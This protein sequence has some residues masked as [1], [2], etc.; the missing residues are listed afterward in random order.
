MVVLEPGEKVID[1]PLGL[2]LREL[3]ERE[4]LITAVEMRAFDRIGRQYSEVGG[5]YSEG[6]VE[7]ERPD[8]GIVAVGIREEIDRYVFDRFEPKLPRHRWPTGTTYVS[9]PREQVVA[10]RPN[11]VLLTGGFGARRSP[12]PMEMNTERLKTLIERLDRELPA[13]WRPVDAVPALSSPPSRDPLFIDFY[14]HLSAEQARA[15]MSAAG[16]GV[17]FIGEGELVVRQEPAVAHRMYPPAVVRLWL[18][19][20]MPTGSA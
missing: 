13:G 9:D 10:M 6:V 3:L 4:Q 7:A 19:E 2:Y 12:G 16:L 1:G 5:Q 8:G 11:L 20:R 17:E 18:G 14:L 15:R